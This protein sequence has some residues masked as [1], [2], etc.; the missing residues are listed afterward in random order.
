MTRIR[1][2][3]FII[4]EKDINPVW[5]YLCSIEEEFEYMCMCAKKNTIYGYIRYKYGKVMTTVQQLLH[6]KAKIA[7]ETKSDTEIRA[8]L[9]KKSTTFYEY[10]APAKR[11]RTQKV[12]EQDQMFMDRIAINQEMLA[13][14]QAMLINLFQQNADRDKQLIEI[15][16]TVALN[17]PPIVYNNNTINNNKVS[18]NLN[19][20]LNEKCKDAM[21]ITAFAK[22][23]PISLDD[24]KMF[25]HLGHAEAITRII[26]KAYRDMELTKRPMHCTDVKRETLYVK[27]EDKWTNDESKAIIEKAINIVANQ[28]FS[29]LKIWKDANPDFCSDEDKKT[30]YARIMRQLLGGVSDKEMEENKAKIIRNIAQM[31]QIDK[32]TALK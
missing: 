27:N 8:E 19:M 22:S 2:F 17:A 26:D 6:Y 30:E 5:V 7:E 15:C 11:S 31:S 1:T 13:S 21:D 18:F 24:I 12:D 14:G 23:I 28:S 9:L 25:Q 3:S 4:K 29:N 20:F 10:G 32:S 16:K